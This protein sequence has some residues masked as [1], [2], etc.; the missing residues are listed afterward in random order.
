VQFLTIAAA[1]NP[2]VWKDHKD[3]VKHDFSKTHL[4]YRHK[5]AKNQQNR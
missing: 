2:A 5:I 3:F 4:F 1:G